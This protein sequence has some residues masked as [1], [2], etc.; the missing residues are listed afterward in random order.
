M[1][2]DK[3]FPEVQERD[4]KGQFR[5]KYREEYCKM[6]V[7]HMSKGLSYE[8]F[9]AVIGT[10]R[11]TLKSWEN[12]HPEFMEAKKMGQDAAQLIWER[13]GL[14]QSMGDKKIGKGSSI[15]WIFTMKNKFKWTDRHEFGVDEET[16]DVLKLTYSLDEQIED[17]GVKDDKKEKDA[18]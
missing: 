4:E 8:T 18:L 3:P 6:L 2:D 16:K 17:N 13:I 15:S 14:A 5:P 12:I 7:E 9:A 1:S 11:D 10:H